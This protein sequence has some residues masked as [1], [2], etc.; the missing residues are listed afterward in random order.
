MA[1]GVSTLS[2]ELLSHAQ[3]LS[4][5]NGRGL[6]TRAQSHV[7]E[8]IWAQ[9]RKN[10]HWGGFNTAR[11]STHAR[12]L[13]YLEIM[14]LYVMRSGVMELMLVLERRPSLYLFN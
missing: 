13:P 11:I 6:V 3:A 7:S 14:Q 4:E 8:S 1:P 12:T 10:D 2:S 9:G 5:S